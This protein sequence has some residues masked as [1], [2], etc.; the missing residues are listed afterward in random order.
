M[1][2]DAIK[3]AKVNL[4]VP[5]QELYSEKEKDATASVMVE[6]QPDAK[7]NEDQIKAIINLVASSVEGLASRIPEPVR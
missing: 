3:N 1:S 7:L 5:Q 2:M 6:L 4:V